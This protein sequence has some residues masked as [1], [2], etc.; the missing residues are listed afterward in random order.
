MSALPSAAPFRRTHIFFA[1]YGAY[2][3]MKGAAA[4]IALLAAPRPIECAAALATVAAGLLLAGAAVN[5]GHLRRA[6]AL[7]LS[8]GC[9]SL[10]TELA[11]LVLVHSSPPHLRG[12]L[13]LSHSLSA[14][15]ALV[16][17][18]RSDALRRAQRAALP[19]S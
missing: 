7:S 6:A 18:A 12:G 1:L 17:L 8:A 15:L 11:Q 9:L 13:L 2:L 16:V 14:T 4:G 19:H 5:V 10:A 3:V